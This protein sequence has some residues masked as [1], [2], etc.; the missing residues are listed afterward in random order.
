MTLTNPFRHEIPLSTRLREMVLNRIFRSVEAK[1][2]TKS[3][4]FLEDFCNGVN[5]GRFTRSNSPGCGMIF[6]CPD[7]PLLQ[8]HPLSLK[9]SCWQVPGKHLFW[10]VKSSNIT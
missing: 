7:V 8:T 1:Q 4:L 3:I 2:R 6:I 10:V 5:N 9:S